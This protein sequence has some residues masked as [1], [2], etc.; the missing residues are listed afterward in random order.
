M[1]VY[2]IKF[3]VNDDMETYTT[4][5]NLRVAGDVEYDEDL[6]SPWNPSTQ[7]ITYDGTTFTVTD[8]DYAQRSTD[9]DAQ[10]QEFFIDKPTDNAN[11]LDVIE[12]ELITLE[13]RII[14]LELNVT[15]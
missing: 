2:Y 4:D 12:P 13:N 3:D 6:N 15:A 9:R 11:R 10:P 1:T 8:I 5:V 7:L 14:Q